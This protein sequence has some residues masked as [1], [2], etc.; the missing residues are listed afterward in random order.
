MGRADTAG[1]YSSHDGCREL[2][3]FSRTALPVEPMPVGIFQ[4]SSGNLGRAFA[5]GQRSPNVGGRNRKGENNQAV[6]SDVGWHLI[7]MA[8][9]APHQKTD[10]AR[11]VPPPV[12]RPDFG[13]GI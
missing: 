11:R 4:H 8:G 1:V 9:A 6:Q 7:D 2:S 3:F 5:A 10:A 13:K 12:P